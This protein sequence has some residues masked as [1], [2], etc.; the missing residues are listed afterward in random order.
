MLQRNPSDE[1]LQTLLNEIRSLV[2]EITTECEIPNLG[3]VKINH[4]SGI[5]SPFNYSALNGK[6]AICQ[7]NRE[8][9][10]DINGESILK[11]IVC[12]IAVSDDRAKR[13][14]NGATK[15]LP[16]TS[17]CLIWIDNKNTLGFKEWGGILNDEFCKNPNIHEKISGVVMFSNN[18]GL[19]PSSNLLSEIYSTSFICNKGAKF[20]IPDWIRKKII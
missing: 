4:I 16:Q 10:T 1:E 20:Q 8:P 14:L 13:F 19:D 15:Q 7:M 11:S 6:S 18:L 5:Y 2:D 9:I 3:L 12:R 17:S